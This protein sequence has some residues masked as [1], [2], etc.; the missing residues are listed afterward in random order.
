[1]RSEVTQMCGICLFLIAA[2]CLPMQ[3]VAEST[4]EKAV[5]ARQS[6]YHVMGQQMGLINATLKGD[7]AFDKPSLKLRAQALDTLGRLVGENYPAGSDKG[8]TKAKPEI[9]KDRQRFKEFALASQEETAK[10]VQA[11]DAGSLDALKEAYGAVSKSCKTCHDEF[12]VK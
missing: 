6:A 4:T 7:L 9:W 1:M 8:D 11:V 10:L 5:R 12:K 3:T 2:A